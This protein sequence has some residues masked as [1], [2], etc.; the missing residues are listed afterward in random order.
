M[1]RLSRQR[2]FSGWLL[3]LGVCLLSINLQ[4]T[5]KGDGTETA[6]AVS[7]LFLDVD[8]P[9]KTDLEW[10]PLLPRELMRQAVLLTASENF[11][12]STRDEVLGDTP[13]LCPPG[14]LQV[15]CT[16]RVASGQMKVTLSRVDSPDDVR[17][18]QAKIE[19]SST[20]YVSGLELAKV[21][22]N[23]ERWSERSRR[24]TP[25][26]GPASRPARPDASGKPLKQVEQLLGV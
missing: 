13:E 21:V 12:L 6:G 2:G 15:D 3:I 22:R 1:D 17:S 7:A 24:S 11:G 8:R 18:I 9:V 4:V 5:A 16:T 14:T 26:M 20:G 25:A 10:M 23:A 19:A